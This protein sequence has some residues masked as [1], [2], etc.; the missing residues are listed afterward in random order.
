M[1]SI[2]LGASASLGERFA[3]IQLAPTWFS[4]QEIPPMV[5][6]EQSIRNNAFKHLARSI[7][8][9]KTK[10]QFLTDDILKLTRMTLDFGDW[11]KD[12]VTE[13]MWISQLHIPEVVAFHE[14]TK[15]GMH[16]LTVR[17]D[18]IRWK[19]MGIFVVN[20]M[21]MGINIILHA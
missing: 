7:N 21:G 12:R 8:S 5:M 15:V 1:S 13:G 4:G 17:V 19:V 20:C 9:M 10:S 11:A 6:T 18:V 2:G 14:N 16:L 3:L